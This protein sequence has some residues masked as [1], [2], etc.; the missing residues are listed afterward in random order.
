MVRGEGGWGAY[1]DT[2]RGFLEDEL[3]SHILLN[4]S[5]D[6]NPLRRSSLVRVRLLLEKYNLQYRLPFVV[7]TGCFL[8]F[9][10]LDLVLFHLRA[11]AWSAVIF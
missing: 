1:S 2:R 4:R 10:F 5:F 3:N 8:G 9:Q 7:G 6:F 11:V